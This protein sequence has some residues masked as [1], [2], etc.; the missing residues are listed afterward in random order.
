VLCKH[1]LLLFFPKNIKLDSKTSV[2]SIERM[3]AELDAR[4]ERQQKFSR[5]RT[6]LEGADVDFINDRNKV[7]VQ[8]HLYCRR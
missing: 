2:A 8:T 3:K 7:L 5:R 4:K 1:V 6:D